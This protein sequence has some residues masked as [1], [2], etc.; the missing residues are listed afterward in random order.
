MKNKEIKE[1][2]KKANIYQWQVAEAMGI[3]ETALSRKMR[4]ELPEKEKK[5]IIDVI[6]ELK[7]EA[8]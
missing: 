1:T 8:V 6:E 4:K 2:L 7:K 5:Q 3:G